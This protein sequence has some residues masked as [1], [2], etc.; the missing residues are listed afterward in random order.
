VK[1]RRYYGLV[2]LAVL[3]LLVGLLLAL[4]LQGGLAENP[5]FRLQ[6]RLDLGTLLLLVGLALA[7]CLAAG[8]A[9]WQWFERR[10]RRALAAEQAET[11]QA[12]QRFIRRL[13]H[14]LKNPL[15]A[16]RT[17]LA[18]LA[19]GSDQQKETQA[20]QDISAQVERLSRLTAD[21]RKVAELETR[22]IEREP[23]NV[24]ELL[25]ELVT[26]VQTSPEY[27]AHSIRLLLPQAP[28][29][30]PLVTGDRD[31]LGLAFYNLLDNACKFTGPEDLIEVRA[32]EED[33]WLVVEVADTGLGIA[34][35]ELPHLFEELYR[36]RN[37]RRVAGS[38]LGLALAQRIAARHG[39]AITVRSRLEQG[40]VFTMR[41]PLP[42]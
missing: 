10:Q 8:V 14:E 7:L 5:L 18:Y 23:V 24:A 1:A 17:T 9:A 2:A 26:A 19:I 40:T 6:A 37:A 42:A 11:A 31:L 4:A 20:W 12:R 16:I 28:W 38:G 27:A 36:G 41:L 30:L 22:P 35:E 13:D 29:P 25:A 34:P 32:A 39:G 3:P 15:A 33:H 21:L